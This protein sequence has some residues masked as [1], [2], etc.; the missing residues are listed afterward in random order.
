M[1]PVARLASTLRPGLH[2]YDR[3]YTQM[4]VATAGCNVSVTT[5]GGKDLHVL[6]EVV[7]DTAA[8]VKQQQQQQ[9]QQQPQCGAAI[10]ENN[11]D[12]PNHDLIKIQNVSS[13]N[14]WSTH[15]PCHFLDHPSS[16]CCTPPVFPLLS[17]SQ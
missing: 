7:G 8:A 5:G 1:S 12:F 17:L 6:V 10:Y 2:A 9:Q 13:V 3:S 16:Q 15:L 14:T 4:Y 11:T